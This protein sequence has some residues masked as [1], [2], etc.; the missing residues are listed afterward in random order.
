REFTLHHLDPASDKTLSYFEKN[1]WLILD[2]S[3]KSL[4]QKALV[5]LQ[6]SQDNLLNLLKLQQDELLVK[7]VVER[8]YSYRKLLYGVIQHDIYHL[9]QIIYIKKM[10]R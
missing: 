1:D 5:R 10:L 7:K 9:G 2:H 3:D 6:Q 4:L 8:N